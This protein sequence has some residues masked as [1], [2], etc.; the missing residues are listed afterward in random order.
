MSESPEEWFERMILE[1]VIEFAGLDP[2]SGEMLYNFSKD[3][4]KISPEV[5]Q[6]M[7]HSME[8]DIYKLWEKGFLAMNIAE[9]NPLVKVTPKSL[10]QD[11]IDQEL[12]DKEKNS[13]E[14]IMMFMSKGNS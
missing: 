8:K 3:L 7:I 10:D 5:F 11:I 4:E 1:G 6:E 9:E 12:N 2:D 14:I 13:L